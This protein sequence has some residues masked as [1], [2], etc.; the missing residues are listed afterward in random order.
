MRPAGTVHP[1]LTVFPLQS[2][3]V[4]EV[5][6]LLVLT[7]KGVHP[8]LSYG[9][10]PTQIRSE[11]GSTF[12]KCALFVEVVL[13]QK[14]RRNEKRKKE[15][16]K[17]RKEEKE[18]KATEKTTLKRLLTISSTTKVLFLCLHS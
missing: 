2:S 15:K 4:H 18:E 5:S 6:N 12:G 7:A 16:K 17:K 13:F 10:S 14:K 11:F 9:L 3:Q 8:L 1:W